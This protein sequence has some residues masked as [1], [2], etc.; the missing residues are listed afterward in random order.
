MNNP[1]FNF[2]TIKQI[3][4]LKKVDVD[5]DIPW[6]WVWWILG[7]GIFIILFFIGSLYLCAYLNNS[8]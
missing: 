4:K 8:L 3:S 5:T 7:I 1:L 6:S 2:W